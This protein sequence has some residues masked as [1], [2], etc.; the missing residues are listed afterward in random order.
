MAEYDPT[1]ELEDMRRAIDAVAKEDGFTRSIAYDSKAFAEAARSASHS[2]RLLPA[3]QAENERLRDERRTLKNKYDLVFGALCSKGEVTANQT[4]KLQARVKELEDALRGYDHMS[5]VIESAVREASRS[6]P[7]NP[8][9]VTAA[10]LAG[11]KALRADEQP[12]GKSD[13]A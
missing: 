10:I 7:A 13:E 2:H 1:R 5:L 3:L 8:K 12:K 4:A 9:A 6:N 11:R